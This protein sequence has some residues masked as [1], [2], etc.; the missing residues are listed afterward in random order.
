LALFW[1]NF[2]NRI[3]QYEFYIISDHFLF[4]HW[5]SKHGRRGSGIKN[6]GF[7]AQLLFPFSI[8]N[9]AFIKFHIYSAFRLSYLCYCSHIGGEE[10]HSLPSVN[11]AR[12]AASDHFLTE[13]KSWISILTVILMCWQHWWFT[14]DWYSMFQLRQKMVGC[15]SPSWVNRW[16]TAVLLSPDMARVTLVWLAL[17]Y[18]YRRLQDKSTIHKFMDCDKS[19]LVSVKI[20]SHN[21]KIIQIKNNL[22]QL[23]RW[24]LPWKLLT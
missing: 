10:Y 4:S 20:S 19:K 6:I 1:K 13:L 15:R 24:R 17:K 3:W 8:L 14:K 5:T 2:N 11:P 7:L 9:M 23:N 12:R 22:Q 18:I 16:E 21:M